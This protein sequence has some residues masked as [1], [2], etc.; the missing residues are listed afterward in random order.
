M[1]AA[2][3]VYGMAGLV[4]SLVLEW[5]DGR[6]RNLGAKTG[7]MPISVKGHYYSILAHSRSGEEKKR[8]MQSDLSKKS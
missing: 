8:K 7:Q 2:V 1:S 5:G 4:S 3:T 6:R